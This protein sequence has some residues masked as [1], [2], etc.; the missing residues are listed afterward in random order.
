[1]KQND[2]EILAKMLLKVTFIM[3][4]ISVF[5]KLLGMDLLV[6]DPN[7]TLLSKICD[8]TFD[9]H[10][11]KVLCVIF[12][13]LQTYI[14]LKISC[15]NEKN[16][17]YFFISLFFTFLLISIQFI[18]YNVNLNQFSENLI[19]FLYFTC[20]F[21]FL[22]LAPIFID[23]KHYIKF[24]KK[25]NLNIFKI[26][27]KKIKIPMKL[28]L[29]MIFYQILVLFL[30]DITYI[31]AHYDFYNLLL[32]FD[33]IILLIAT[34]YIYLVRKENLNFLNHNAF[35]LPKF[36]NSIPSKE[37]IKLFIDKI[38][39]NINKF[40]NC[41]KTDKV[42][43]VVYIFLFA[44]SELFNLSLIIF[45]AYLNDAIVECFFIITSFMISRQVFGALHLDS[46]IKCW[47]VSNISFFILNKLTVSVGVSLVIPIFF[48][49]LLSYITSRFI[50]E[51]NIELYRGMEEEDLLKIC[52]NKKL[53]KL[54]MNILID[55]YCNRE[56][57]V[58]L[59]RKYHY[60]KTMIHEY[61]SKALKKIENNNL[62]KKNNK[63]SK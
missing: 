28:I 43:F 36:L 32:N 15:V 30:R 50:K 17:I 38:S 31:N 58:K 12:V 44:C 3:L 29:L 8:I 57:I 49:L 26:I 35:I 63:K 62:V 4:C 5:L 61:K 1:M 24:K 18:L 14:F 16:F 2:K 39:D 11:N 40:K 45:I 34:Y 60:S 21:L 41:S 27:L 48:G 37:D 9:Y 56:S 51:T 6:I 19:S 54:E 42:V 13:F 22:I 7:D 55:F 59:T 20:S 52:K 46:A 23:L 47:F 33:Y 25:K 10:I 53:T